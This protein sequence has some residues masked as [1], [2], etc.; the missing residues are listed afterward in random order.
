MPRVYDV[1]AS[2][3][4]SFADV[5]YLFNHMS[6]MSVAEGDLNNNNRIDFADIVYLNTR[7]NQVGK[8]FD[9]TAGTAGGASL[10]YRVTND[11]SGITTSVT[12]AGLKASPYT[13]DFVTGDI[14]YIPYPNS[15]DNEAAR[16]TIA[17]NDPAQY[18]DFSS[19][20]VGEIQNM[21]KYESSKL[22]A[23]EKTSLNNAI[24]IIMDLTQSREPFSVNLGGGG[25]EYSMSSDGKSL[26]ST[27]TTGTARTLKIDLSSGAITYTAAGA[28]PVTVTKASNPTRYR[29]YCALLL[30]DFRSIFANYSGDLSDSE[31]LYLN[32]AQ[33]AVKDFLYI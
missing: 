31:K 10:A 21:L 20:M 8:T 12:G 32:H 24:G 6:S 25:L 16:V 29:D 14:S 22:S 2:G 1:D 17:K 15:W 26:T 7:V 30:S 19:R 18:A 11:G 13:I 3:T 33:E 4:V 5:T 23:A 28:A 9:I 27:V